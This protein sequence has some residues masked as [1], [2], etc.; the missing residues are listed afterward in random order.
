MLLTDAKSAKRVKQPWMPIPG[1]SQKYALDTRCNVTLYHGARGP[2][3]TDTQLMRFSQRV[4]MGYGVYWRGVI[5]DRE[6]K[7]LDDLVAKSRRHFLGYNDG[8]RFLSSSS[9]YKWV[10]PTGE[11]LLFRQAKK[12][13]DYWNYHGQEFPYIGWNELCKYPTPELFD[14][15]MS[16]NRSSFTVEKDGP[17]DSKGHPLG[18]KPI[19]LEVFATAN[20]Y[21][22]G[23]GWVKRRFIDPAPSGTIIRQPTN[24]FDP[25]TKQRITVVRTQIA[26]FGSYKENI[27]LDP[28]YVANL[29]NE[30]DPNKRKAWLEGDWN[31]IAGG[32]IDDVWRTDIH[33]LPRFPVPAGWR[34]D[35][36][37]DWG[38]SH[39]A[40]CT[41]WAE[42]DG[43]EAV[44]PNGKKFCPPK[45]SLVCIAELYFC[46]PKQTNVGLKWSASRIAEAI[47]DTEIRLMTTGP[48]RIATAPQ[49]TWISKQP[50]PGPADNQIRNVIM[51]D[52]DTIETQMQKAGIR[53]T[54]SD[55]GKGSRAV[56]L[57]LVRDRL[58]NSIEFARIGD[59][60][61]GLYV[62]SNCRYCIATIPM[63]PR[64]ELNPDDVDTEAEDHCYDT[65]RYRVLAA[66]NRYATKFK[67]TFPT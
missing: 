4:G 26:I 40:A 1:S 16:C 25:K 5:F 42:A 10:W 18:I 21:G 66:G 60:K 64:D 3:K 2:G 67:F 38:S 54:A 56:G 13:A 61:P 31:V 36:A 52:I 33:I 45:G 37:F 14:A 11:E 17:V 63:L 58:F 9:D 47:R 24:V 50:W 43:T 20:P 39:P 62:T 12:P 15:M 44:L 35:R 34:V 22:P 29:E 51:S 27:Y 59:A 65:W 32:A 49:L 57:Q 28:A 19:P 30:S 23:H 46:D 55:K 48:L 7:M 53:W 41:W 6:Y 8:A